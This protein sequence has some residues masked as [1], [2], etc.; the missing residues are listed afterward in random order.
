MK[1]LTF[2]KL[3]GNTGGSMSEAS[4]A[5]L[6]YLCLQETCLH[7]VCKLLPFIRRLLLSEFAFHRQLSLN[8]EPC[9]FIPSDLS[10]WF[11][12]NDLNVQFK[13]L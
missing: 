3:I 6:Y 4:F 5:N 7:K 11:H 9:K 2:L 8:K 12:D 13:F 10:M 1:D